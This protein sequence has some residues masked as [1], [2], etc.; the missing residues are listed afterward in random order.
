MPLSFLPPKILRKRK[1]ALLSNMIKSMLLRNKKNK[2]VSYF[3]IVLLKLFL[4]G[5][6]S[7][8]DFPW[9]STFLLQLNLDALML[10]PITRDTYLCVCSHY[11]LT[12][13]PLFMELS[14]GFLQALLFLLGENVA[15]HKLSGKHWA[16]SDPADWKTPGMERGKWLRVSGRIKGSIRY[17]TVKQ[18][19]LSTSPSASCCP[20]QTFLATTLFF[21]GM[22]YNYL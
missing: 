11:V 12:H 14:N 4:N 10:S 8:G 1:R 22:N 16:L 13:L 2:I 5:R 15:R 7:C 21:S 9:I 3:I 19:R 17:Y 6:P 20:L 18:S